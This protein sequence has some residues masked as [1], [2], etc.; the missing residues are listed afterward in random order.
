MSATLSPLSRWRDAT[1]ALLGISAT[2]SLARVVASVCIAG[3][4]IGAPQAHAQMFPFSQR[5]SVAQRLAFTDIA[6][7]YG[8][9]TAR[10]RALFGALV[11]WNA[12]WHPGADSATTLSVSRDITIEGKLLPA[13][14][15]SV[16]LVPHDGAP[17]TLI[18]SRAVGVPHTP[19][20]GASQDQ[21]RVD[22]TA[23]RASHVETLT[24]AFPDVQRDDATL[25]LQWGELGLSLRVKAPYRPAESR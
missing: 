2:G 1:R 12:V 14:S 20:P 15:Y 6:I 25:R 3:A 23:S 11:P 17:W 4:L 19:Y 22:V 21:L 13:G 24:F 7:E 8:R 18:L 16:W 9:P 10:G 5:G